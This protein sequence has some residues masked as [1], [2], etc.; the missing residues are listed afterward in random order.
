MWSSLAGDEKKS[1]PP[2][3]Q[4]RSTMLM[5]GRETNGKGKKG[6]VM[7]PNEQGKPAS[8]SRQPQ[9]ARYAAMKYERSLRGAFISQHALFL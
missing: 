2:T 7:A 4:E 3:S 8:P 1:A 9:L 6:K 5:E